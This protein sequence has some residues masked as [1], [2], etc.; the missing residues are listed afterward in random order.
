MTDIEKQRQIEKK[1]AATINRVQTPAEAFGEKAG[2][3][4]KPP[5][6]PP[7]P[8]PPSPMRENAT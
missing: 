4:P 7:P 1:L 3:V 8:P 2:G 5:P 6:P